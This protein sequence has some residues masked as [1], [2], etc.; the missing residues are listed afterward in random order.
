MWKIAGTVCI[1]VSIPLHDVFVKWTLKP[2]PPIDTS[3]I[4]NDEVYFFFK[5]I[6]N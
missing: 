4:C 5:E 3:S 6:L 2:Q 1:W